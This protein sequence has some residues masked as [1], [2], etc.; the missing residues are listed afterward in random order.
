MDKERQPRSQRRRNYN[1]LKKRAKRNSRVQPKLDV[2]RTRIRT[3]FR[4]IHTQQNHISKEEVLRK[5]KRRN[6][7]R[8]LGITIE[9]KHYAFPEQL[10]VP[11]G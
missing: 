7:L 6:F 11:Q 8:G 4:R 10:P 9:K 3:K 1:A 2:G 5:K